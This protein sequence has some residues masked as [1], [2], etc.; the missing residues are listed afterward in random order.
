[1]SDLQVLK[2]LEKEISTKLNKIDTFFST[3]DALTCKEFDKQFEENPN[4]YCL[5]DKTNLVG[6]IIKTG[7]EKFPK[8]I[9][10]FL[11]LEF[12]VLDSYDR[13]LHEL[14][15]EIGRLTNLQYLDLRNNNFSYIPKEIGNLHNLK[16]LNFS[17]NLLSSIPK[18]IANLVNLNFLF[19]ND[20]ELSIL[21]EEISQ[22]V[23]LQ[24][25]NLKINRLSYIPGKINE[26]V[27]LNL[28]DLNG[29][30]L[31]NLP[32]SIGDLIN[33][34]TLDL[35]QNKLSVLP[36]SVGNLI[37][38]KFLMLFDNP[39]ESPPEEIVRKGYRAIIDYLRQLIEKGK[40]RIYEAKFLI[41]GE[42]GAGKTTL[43]KKIMDTDYKLNEDDPFTAGINVLR[44]QF[45]RENGQQPFF[46]NIWDFGGQEI[47][48][49][50]HQFFL[51][52]RSLYALV[53]DNRKEDTVFH[54]WLE[55]ISLLSENS[56]LLII[57]NKKH[58]LDPDINERQ[59]RSQF[60]HLKD[61]LSTNLATNE[62]LE[63]IVE[64]IR[65][66]IKQLPHI[67][68]V[69]PNTWIN[70]RKT[71]EKDRRN[72]IGL[73]EYLKICE[74]NGIDDYRNKLQ[75]SEYLHDIGV[76]L[77]FMDDPVLKHLIILKPEWATGAVYKVLFCNQV[78]TNLGKFTKQN[79]K[80][81][82]HEKQY[83]GI[84]DELLQLM[85]NFQLCY[86][87]PDQKENYIA[88]Q[89]LPKNQPMYDW[90]SK[91]NLH[92]RYEYE[93]MPK[94]I[95]AR[96]IVASHERIYKQ[97]FVWQ[98]G[99]ILNIRDTKAEI[100]ED[101][102]AR[103]ILIRASGHNK[104]NL[105]I[106]VMHE[107]DKIH[108]SY[109]GLNYNKMIPCCCSKCVQSQEPNFFEYNDLIERIEKHQ[110]KVR[111][112]ENDYKEIGVYELLYGISSYDPIDPKIPKL[113]SR[114]E[115]N[116]IFLSYS[117]ED[118]N[119]KDQLMKHL[120]A[121]ENEWQI[122]TWSDRKITPGK[123][124][125]QEIRKAISH[126]KIAVLLVSADYLSSQFIIHEEV[127]ALLEKLNNQTLT[128]I[129]IIIKPCLWKHISWLKELNVMPK[130]G[131]PLLT[132]NN[133]DEILVSIVDKIVKI[134]KKSLL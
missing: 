82:W 84:E 76:C 107:L 104:Q 40:E 23:N 66:H 117:H 101:Y 57:K 45:D 37:N 89:L 127:P 100:I 133:Q 53:A 121:L 32:D 19:L 21:P 79:L 103:K 71:I 122:Y 50:T 16:Y 20:N 25:L 94:G 26:L 130:D 8:I 38:L 77:H 74:D 63:K 13:I 110:Y 92:L 85:M 116:T 128:I 42:P 12:L 80:E 18:E 60:T 56:P 70:V 44:C 120:N 123:K 118:E 72:Y 91:D 109:H 86:E 61:I 24:I 54:Y 88:P 99:V 134:S 9:F 119:L 98:T 11:N 36:E 10:T 131:K 124:W 33:L 96:F 67:G 78:K 48:H 65:H 95:I 49:S 35:S 30:E 90:D 47:L 64:H 43:A 87:I 112:K 29:N 106:I 51:T 81:I 17:N 58:D 62:G 22:L 41:V 14:P 1:M 73:D 7:I 55:I 46:M 75:L 108:G 68:T 125:Y 129:P 102:Q 59:L 6:L 97:K 69:L 111:C 114:P 31:S 115:Q 27:N 113:F 4:S 52:K 2:E 34:T 93:F 83:W 132:L 126:A 105:I 15:P 28:L 39:L 3:T 5:D